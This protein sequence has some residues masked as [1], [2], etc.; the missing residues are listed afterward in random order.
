MT[1]IADRMIR[2]QLCE[3]INYGTIYLAY[4][5]F[6][7]LIN[8]VLLQAAYHNLKIGEF[9]TLEIFS[10]GLLSSLV[11]IV[12]FIFKPIFGWDFGKKIFNTFAQFTT[13]S[14][15]NQRQRGLPELVMVGVI[16]VIFTLANFAAIAWVLSQ[17]NSETSIVQ[18]PQFDVVPCE[19]TSLVYASAGDTYTKLQL[20]VADATWACILTAP[21]D[22]GDPY[23]QPDA[24]SQAIPT[25]EYDSMTPINAP[26]AAISST[27]DDRGM[28]V[29]MSLYDVQ[30]YVRYGVLFDSLYLT[31]QMGDIKTVELTDSPGHFIVSPNGIRDLG[32]SPM[33]S[34]LCMN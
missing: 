17:T 23:T 22:A 8:V 9:F 6:L 28:M 32:E 27:V 13:R 16:Y 3:I 30:Y 4:M 19:S 11:W 31:N 24:W 34:T 2:M 5:F 21:I 18:L 20:R 33:P 25:G 12:A 29:S 26:L 15:H 1:P 7:F 14:A 10:L